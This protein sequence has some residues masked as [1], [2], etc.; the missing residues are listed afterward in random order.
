MPEFD[1]KSRTNP[2]SKVDHFPSTCSTP[3][4]ELAELSAEYRFPETTLDDFL[5]QFDR[6]ATHG[7]VRSTDRR[8]DYSIV[9]EGCPLI[10]VGGIVSPRRL[11][12]PLAVVASKRYRTVTYDHPGINDD[13]FDRSRRSDE[14]FV[15]DLFA[16]AD[17]L[18][19]DS[20]A[21]VGQSFGVSIAIRAAARSPG[22]ISK[23]LLA[24][25]FVDRPLTSFEKRLAELAGFW[26]GRLISLPFYSTISR[27]NYRR[28]LDYRSTELHPFVHRLM[29]STP[30]RVASRHLASVAESDVSTLLEKVACPTLVAHGIEDRLIGPANAGRLAAK[31]TDVRVMLIPRCGHLPHLSHPE[32]LIEA[33]DRIDCG[34][35]CSTAADC[36]SGCPGSAVSA[37]GIDRANARPCET[38]AD[39]P[40]HFN[41]A[42]IASIEPTI[43]TGD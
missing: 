18:K 28:E 15:D 1:S 5:S 7:S 17:H 37:S 36:E 34:S 26:P 20:F 23:A 9:G 24:A 25:G 14:P 8:I 16:L 32:L 29:G 42:P 2:D 39:C 6:S 3:P 40:S 22:R 4:G 19:F 41:S 43:P 38:G 27:H 21:V 31:L 13:G 10:I 35:A 33:L 30:A 12:A 11:Y